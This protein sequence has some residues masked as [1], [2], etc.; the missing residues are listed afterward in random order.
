MR[1]KFLPLYL[2]VISALFGVISVSQTFAVS[3]DILVD[4]A[5]SNPAPYENTNITLKSYVYNLDVASIT[6]SVDGKKVSSGV[7]KKSFSVTAPGAGSEINV[8]AT[9]SLPDTVTETKILIKPIVMVLLWQANDSYV[10]PFYR[11]KALAS[12]ESQVKVVAMPEIKNASGNIIPPQ[13]MA[14]YWAKDFTNNVDGSGYGK[15]FF[16]FT[17]DYLENSNN[18]SV[19]LTTTDQ[20]LTPSANIY[21]GMVQPKLL[22][23]KNDPNIGTIWQ[24]SLADTHKI[25]GSEILEAIPYFISPKYIQIPTLSWLWSI[26]DESVS[27]TGVRKNVMPLQTQE[28]THG[29]SKVGLEINN[30]DKVFQTTKKEINI[31]F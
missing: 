4:V 5:P 28:G 10:P 23:Y 3:T 31:E 27:V 29:I 7:G 2:V 25:Q 13:N 8:V 18:I 26:N 17:N 22:F 9:I 11:G 19:K 1:F 21:I 16:T 14:Y 30:R 6:W 24:N 15:N 20:D 12:P